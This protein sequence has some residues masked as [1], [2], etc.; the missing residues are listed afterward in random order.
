M[1][2]ATTVPNRLAEAFRLVNALPSA[3]ERKILQETYREQLAIYQKGFQSGLRRLLS[4]AKLRE[5]KN[6]PSPSMQP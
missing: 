2:S 5:T 6:C 4:V 1:A 3:N